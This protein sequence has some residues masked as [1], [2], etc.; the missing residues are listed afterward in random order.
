MAEH[1]ERDGT[2]ALFLECFRKRLNE[3]GDLDKIRSEIRAKILNDVRDG[4][5]AP[6][7]SLKSRG[8]KSPTQ[9]A[10]HLVLEYLEWMG[11]Q[12]S[13]E[14]LATESGIKTASRD[15]I[16]SKLDLNGGDKELPSLLNMIGKSLKK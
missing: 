4:N 13:K 16:E 7:N 5:Q 11:F 10:S 2:E 15:F 14:M 3:K 12:F 6:M 9:I 8:Q 1:P